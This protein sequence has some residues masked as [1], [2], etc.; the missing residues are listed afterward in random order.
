MVYIDDDDNIDADLEEGD[1]D[2]FWLNSLSDSYQRYQ[3]ELEDAEMEIAYEEEE[4][5]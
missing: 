3:E 2:Y 4:L 1:L 5:G